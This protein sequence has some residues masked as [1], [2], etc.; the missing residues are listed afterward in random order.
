MRARIAASLVV[1]LLALPLMSRM[2]TGPE[3]AGDYLSHIGFAFDMYRGNGSVPHPLFH[4]I[5]LVLVGGDNPAPAMKATIF[6]MAAALAACAWICAGAILRAK[7][8]IQGIYVALLCLALALAFPLPTWWGADALAGQMGGNVWH[9]PTGIVAMPF[10]LGLYL[11][12]CRLIEGPRLGLAATTG[13]LM[14][15]SLLAKPSYVLAFAPCFGLLLIAALWHAVHSRS[16]R[17]TSAAAIL[18]VSCGPATAI[19]LGQYIWLHH[20]QQ[21][22]IYGQF[23]ELW[24]TWS[25]YRVKESIALGLVYPVVVMLA[26]P[27]QA[28]VSRPLL[29][30]WGTMLTGMGIFACFMEGGGRLLNAN[31]AWCVTYGNYVLFAA[32]TFFLLRQRPGLAQAIC[33]VALVLHAASGLAWIVSFVLGRGGVIF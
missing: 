11:V 9:S 15:L 22:L 25:H 18:L 13:A 33:L 21:G 4:L 26:Y 31:F 32:S 1:F 28:N 20:N 17:F 24:Q 2:A 16:L 23:F 10:A 3:Y 6:I 30:A 12:A 8:G 27:R 14:V 19:L 7:P 5:L 29:L